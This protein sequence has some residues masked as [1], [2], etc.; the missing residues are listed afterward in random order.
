MS[1]ENEIKLQ[2]LIDSKLKKP[3]YVDEEIRRINSTSQSIVPNLK[4]KKNQKK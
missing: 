1:T 3:K 2:K 4:T